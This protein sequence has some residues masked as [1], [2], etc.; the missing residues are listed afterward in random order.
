MKALIALNS[1]NQGQAVL[2]DIYWQRNCL[3]EA[4]YET[5]ICVDGSPTAIRLAEKIKM[6]E[7]VK[8]SMLLLNYTGLWERGCALFASSGCK[9]AIRLFGEYSGAEEGD[10]L[11]RI[12]EEVARANSGI[13]F[14][15]SRCSLIACS[16]AGIE[17]GMLSVL[18]VNYDAE[19]YDHIKAD[20][21][22]LHRLIDG[23]IN[24]II[25]TSNARP[26]YLEFVFSATRKYLK[27]FEKKLRLIV[28]ENV[29]KTEALGAEDKRPDESCDFS[30]K[31]ATITRPNLSRRK[32]LFLASHI[33]LVPSVCGGMTARILESQYFKVPV[34]LFGKGF[35][36]DVSGFY[37]CGDCS[38]GEL[39]A[40]IYAYF[41]NL[42]ARL[43]LIEKGIEEYRKYASI[44]HKFVFTELLKGLK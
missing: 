19:F 27:F 11:N 24:V 13:I 28:V 33:L 18:P 43:E 3:V 9:K 12:A 30:G 25:E 21:E 7:G 42:E 6:I 36:A 5:E 29:K 17:S 26:D 41:H 44:S 34:L 15:D 37:N 20:K 8:D 22:F 10:T 39:A 31:M 14:C 4:G 35:H 2:K 32:A 1:F 40:G 16:A 38:S 23:K